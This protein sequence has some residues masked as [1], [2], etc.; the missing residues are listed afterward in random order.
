MKT[1]FFRRLSHEDKA[2]APHEAVRA[3]GEE[4]APLISPHSVLLEYRSHT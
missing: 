4:A 3:V 1:L 2:T